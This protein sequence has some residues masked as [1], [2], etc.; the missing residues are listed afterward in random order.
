MQKIKRRR[1]LRNLPKDFNY[2]LLEI[3]A[4]GFKTELKQLSLFNMFEFAYVD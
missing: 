3:L 2:H 1:R 4:T